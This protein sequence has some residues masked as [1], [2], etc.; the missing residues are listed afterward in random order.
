MAN[1]HDKRIPT[2][3]ACVLRP[4]LE[5]WS[6]SQPDKV[7]VKVSKS[8][9]VTFRQMRDLALAAAAMTKL[10]VNRLAHAL[11]DLASHMDNDQFALA[12]LSDDHREGPEAYLG[13]RKPRFKGR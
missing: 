11:D 3:D 4:L 7:F 6:A 2:T 13:R 1:A 12:S 9:E 8:E 10:T 5:K